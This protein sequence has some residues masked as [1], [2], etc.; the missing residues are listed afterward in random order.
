V[1]Q[2]TLAREISFSGIGLHTG[3]KSRVVLKPALVNSGYLFQ[4]VD[5]PKS[6]II[7]AIWQNVVCTENRTVLGVEDFVVNTV[8][9]LLS[10]LVGCGIDNCLIEVNGDEVPDL[11]GAALKFSNLILEA[12][13]VGLAK[14]IAT[15][16]VVTPLIVEDGDSFVACLPSDGYSV[17]TYVDFEEPETY[18]FKFDENEYY[19]QIASARTTASWNAVLSLWQ[20]KLAWG[21]SFS[22][23]G[24]V[25]DEFGGFNATLGSN[26]AARHKVLDF[27]GDLAL[28]GSNLRGRFFCHKAGHGLH[29]NFMKQLSD[30][31]CHPSKQYLN[32]TELIVKK[33]RRIWG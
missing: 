26:E 2:T 9:H 19:N 29:L 18:L 25:G 12:G 11:D 21:G 22:R 13:I 10:A 23:V 17:S 15:V 7:K 3:E 28:F 8:E 33:V 14:D 24:F 32:Y 4:R 6:P 27:I 20:K 1:K 5:L 16:E 31:N 30:F